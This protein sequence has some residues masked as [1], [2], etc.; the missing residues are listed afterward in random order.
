MKEQGKKENVIQRPTTIT[1]GGKPFTVTNDNLEYA[2]KL[3]GQEKLNVLSKG[4]WDFQKGAA[5]PKEM[6]SKYNLSP[7]KLYVRTLVKG[8]G[9]WGTEGSTYK[10]R[11]YNANTKDAIIESLGRRELGNVFGKNIPKTGEKTF[12]NVYDKLNSAAATLWTSAGID[13]PPSIGSIGATRQGNGLYM[14]GIQAI[15]VNHLAAE[16]PGYHYFNQFRQ[17]VDQLDFDD[18]SNVQTSFTGA[19]TTGA[20]NSFERNGKV[21]ALLQGLTMDADNYKSKLP[22]FE[23]ASQRI[24]MNNAGKGAM[25]IYPDAEWLKKYMYSETEKGKPSSGGVISRTEYNDILKNGISIITNS[26]NWN[27]SLFKKGAMSPVESVID[28]EGQ[29][30]YEDTFGNGSYTI[31]KNMYG[32]GKYKITTQATGTDPYTGEKIDSKDVGYTDENPDESISNVQERFKALN[33]YLNQ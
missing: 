19:T 11:E 1:L 8:N 33:E 20:K 2:V 18:F 30:T 5:Y 21:R 6:Q 31:E 17:D 3:A 14:T 9:L 13:T 25:I 24:A 7:N 10:F 4:S 32:N 16:T 26:N 15:G 29:Y 12:K 23:I 27:N 28:Y 22:N